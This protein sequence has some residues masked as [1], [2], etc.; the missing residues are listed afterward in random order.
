[1]RP[2]RDLEV[3]SWEEDS[4][5]GLLMYAA[6]A[7][8]IWCTS[9]DEGLTLVHTLPRSRTVVRWDVDKGNCVPMCLMLRRTK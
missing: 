3:T 4:G 7:E 8:S 5:Q 6:R 9:E 2:L 1:M